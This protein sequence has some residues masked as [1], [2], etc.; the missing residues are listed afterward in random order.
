MESISG[1][2]WPTTIRHILVVDC[3]SNDILET[4]FTSNI[5]AFGS[6]DTTL[7]FKVGNIVYQEVPIT[8]WWCR[9]IANYWAHQRQSRRAMETDSVVELVFW[10]SIFVCVCRLF[11][12]VKVQNIASGR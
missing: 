12:A 10:K 1:G 6:K 3:D 5:M 2:V 8:V 4:I 7:L 11:S 9:R